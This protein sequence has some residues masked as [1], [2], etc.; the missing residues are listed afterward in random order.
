MKEKKMQI[1]ESLIPYAIEHKDEAMVICNHEGVIVYG[2]QKFY[3]QLQRERGDTEETIFWN[4]IEE[5]S[6]KK[7]YNLLSDELERPIQTHIKLFKGD[8]GLLFIHSFDFRQTKHYLFFF[9]PIEI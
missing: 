2:N 1:I 3:A 4:Y 8:F 9:K 7:L 5:E 6:L